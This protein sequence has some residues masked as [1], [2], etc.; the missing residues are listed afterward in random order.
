LTWF[1]DYLPPGQLVLDA[2]VLINLLACGET[3]DVFN[4]LPKPCFVEEKVFQEISRH[5]V[6]GLCHLA[7]LENLTFTGCIEKIRMN[8]E[9]YSHFIA[10]VQA[11]L[12]QR[13]DAGESATLSVAKNRGLV[14]VIDENKGRSYAAR[15][16]PAVPYISSLKLL[17]SA[18]VRSGKD[19]SFLRNL[20]AATREN[21]R[22]GI[23]KDERQLYAEITAMSDVDSK[24]KLA[25]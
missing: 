5:P 13:L 4:A 14:V 24:A 21:A 16:M 12:G 20:I 19:H 11:P 15:N 10:L 25:L 3:S 9:E 2:S 7:A 8:D 23:A 17:I 18:T 1:R 22:M 6:P